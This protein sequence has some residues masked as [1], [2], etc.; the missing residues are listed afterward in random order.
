MKSITLNLT[1]FKSGKP[2]SVRL[3]NIVNNRATTAK[4]IGNN[5]WFRTNSNL[6]DVIARCDA[7]IEERRHQIRN[8]EEISRTCRERLASVASVDRRS[9][10]V[11]DEA[12]T[13]T[14]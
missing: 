9:V 4:Y 12:E 13:P 6:V 7:Q 5:S 8:L 1:G 2:A 11:A 3:S 14:L 10:L